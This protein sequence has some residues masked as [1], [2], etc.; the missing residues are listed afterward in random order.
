MRG[1][2]EAHKLLLGA[3]GNKVLSQAGHFMRF[4]VLHY[5]LWIFVVVKF[6]SGF[7]FELIL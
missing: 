6:L 1:L 5:V 3:G 7:K 4:I 2:S